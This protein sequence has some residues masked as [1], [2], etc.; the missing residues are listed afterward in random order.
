MDKFGSAN[1]EDPNSNRSGTSGPPDWPFQNL[2]L[3]AQMV[4]TQTLVTTVTGNPFAGLVVDPVRQ[5]ACKGPFSVQTRLAILSAIR[6]SQA[7]MFKT[8]DS[9]LVSAY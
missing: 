9:A 3:F 5:P 1:V 7:A 6:R 8:A 2:G 4:A